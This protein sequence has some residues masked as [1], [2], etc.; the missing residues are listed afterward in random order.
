[1]SSRKEPNRL[2][3]TKFFKLCQAIQ[4]NEAEFKAERPGNAMEAEKRTRWKARNAKVRQGHSK[5][6]EGE[7][8]GDTIRVDGAVIFSALGEWSDLAKL[9]DGITAAGFGDYA[10]E[11]RTAQAAL[12]DAMTSTFP[13]HLIEQLEA[14]DAWEICEV[15]RGMERN[16]YAL[17]H[18]VTLKEG[19]KISLSNYN[20]EVGT[21]LV[22]NFNTY[23]GLVRCSGVTMCLTKIL[24]RLGGT[25]LRPKGSIYWLPGY[26]VE[27]WEKVCAAVE[28]A[29]ACEVE[30]KC[31]I[32]RHAMD[33]DALKA[34]RDAIVNEVKSETSRIQEEIES[35]DLGERAL[36]HRKDQALALKE[37]IGQY[38]EA[39]NVGLHGLVGM[40]EKVEQSALAA[41]L[42]ATAGAA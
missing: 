10:P 4:A 28:A 3:Q 26:Q 40:V 22:N 2:G 6:K 7:M 42:M 21:R 35:G 17:R 20:D 39:L 38:E 27:R 11:P 31:Y 36:S 25:S 34:V 5:T 33:G 13:K 15:I 19:P 8:N 24:S 41:A 12:K 9:R 16:E 23:L 1:M 18:T 32:I 14:R 37:K 29:C 30:N